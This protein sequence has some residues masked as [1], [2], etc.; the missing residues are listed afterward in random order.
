MPAPYHEDLD[1]TGELLLLAARGG[2]S[3]SDHA[4]IARLL[5]VV[6]DEALLAAART[7][8]VTA[9]VADALRDALGDDIPSHWL[10]LSQANEARV[11][12]QLDALAAVVAR[13][14]AADIPSAAIESAGTLLGSALPTRAFGSGDL[15]LLVPEASWDAVLEAYAAEGFVPADRRERPTRRA[16]LRRIRDEGGPEPT[17][18]WLE[19]GSAPFDRMWLPLRFEDRCPAWL[20]RRVPSCKRDDLW[21]L[22]PSDA[23]VFVAYHTSLHSFVRAPGVRLHVDVDRVTRDNPLDWV[24]VVREARALGAPTRVFVSFAMARGLLGTPIPDTV[25]E[26]LAPAAW[27]WR[28]IAALLRRN[29]VIADGRPKLRRLEAALLDLLIDERSPASWA[30]GVAVPPTPWM[31]EHFN[32]A[33]APDVPAWRL[34]A[35][36]ARALATRWRPE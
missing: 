22:D 13:L 10:E 4:E 24:H 19:V 1:P 21:V 12:G 5:Q 16:E 6:G 30:L 9:L 34:H 35:R 15:D 14:E 2:R 17:E 11:Q 36:R 23:L 32:R 25:L 8:K 33:A 26:A 29:S 31:H 27:R 20:S 7:N 18:R 3:P 28:R